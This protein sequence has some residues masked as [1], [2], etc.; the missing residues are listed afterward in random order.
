MLKLDRTNWHC[1]RSTNG[2]QKGVGTTRQLHALSKKDAT[3][4]H[5]PATKELF[6]ERAA[7]QAELPRYH[8]FH[9][10]NGPKAID[11]LQMQFCSDG[12]SCE[13]PR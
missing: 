5:V 12:S 7:I 4:D 6:A 2:S 9:L 11:A 8:T 1:A 3:A 10:S 13:T